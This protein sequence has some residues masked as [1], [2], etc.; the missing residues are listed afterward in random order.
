VN[1]RKLRCGSLFAGIGGIDLAFE[2]AGFETVWYSELDQHCN[3][4][5]ARRF[6]GARSVG[7]IIKFRPDPVQDAVDAIFG[8]SPCHARHL[9]KEVK[10]RG[11]RTLAIS[12][13][14]GSDS[15]PSRMPVEHRL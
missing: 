11:L 6:P 7:N 9:R 8:G 2:R 1:E 13:L 12:G 15:S 4:L 5:L 10:E 3:T 14:I